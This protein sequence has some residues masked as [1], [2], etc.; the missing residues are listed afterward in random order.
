LSKDETV[1]AALRGRRPCQKQ[2][3]DPQPLPQ[4]RKV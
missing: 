3:K 4:I 1:V 2:K